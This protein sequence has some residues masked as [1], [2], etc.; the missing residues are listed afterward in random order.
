MES[1]DFL[2]RISN[3]FHLGNYFDVL[4]AYNDYRQS[5]V[6]KK[7]PAAQF[8]IMVFVQQAIIHAMRNCEGEVPAYQGLF[9]DQMQILELFL[10]YFAVTLMPGSAQGS[11]SLLGELQSEDKPGKLSDAEWVDLKTVL[12]NALSF[13]CN[14]F[15]SL[16]KPSPQYKELCFH[17]NGLVFLAFE[18]NHQYG[19]ADRLLDDLK[20]S[21]D[22]H[23][24]TGFCSVRQEMRNRHYESAL[25]R[26]VEIREKFGDS[27]RLGSLRA[28]C[29][30]SL[31][32]FEEV[33]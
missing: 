12:K 20:M 28:S 25:D 5:G 2:I 27:L 18:V 32:R 26:I 8:Q 3:D 13:H 29:L 9:A 23:I 33:E 16:S 10:K 17:F 11:E 30:L 21:N 6:F 4:E 1:N 19:E 7:D 15:N 24:V 31:L 14:Q 22:E